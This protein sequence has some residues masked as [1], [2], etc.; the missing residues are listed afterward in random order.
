[1][2]TISNYTFENC[3]I[4]SVRYHHTSTM[5][6]PSYWVV[7]QCENEGS[8][9]SGMTATNASCGYLISSS[10]EDVKVKEIKLHTTKTGRTIIDTITK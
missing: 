3:T 4:L 9:I 8:V 2:A 1:M 7:F 6:N 10:W 5:G